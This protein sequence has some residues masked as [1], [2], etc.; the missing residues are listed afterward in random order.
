MRLTIYTFTT[1]G[2]NFKKLTK[3]EHQTPSHIEIDISAFAI[4]AKK[5]ITERTITAI[6]KIICLKTSQNVLYWRTHAKTVD[7]RNIHESDDG[8][9]RTRFGWR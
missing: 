5:Q 7:N 1:I 9:I 2:L 3:T 8:F 4:P 6:C